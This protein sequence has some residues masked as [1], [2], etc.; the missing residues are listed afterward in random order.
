M[1]LLLGTLQTCLDSDAID[2]CDRNA[3]LWDNKNPPHL[4]FV[5]L[6]TNKKLIKQ[7]YFS[8]IF[9]SKLKYREINI[10]LEM[11]KWRTSL[12]YLKVQCSAAQPVWKALYCFLHSPCR[13]ASRSR[14]P[15]LCTFFVFVQVCTSRF[16]LTSDMHGQNSGHWWCVDKL[17]LNW[18]WK[19]FIYR[20]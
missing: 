14:H 5:I 20:T 7:I 13:G 11:T 6:L 8:W 19:K 1:L 4:T 2:E 9:S 3:W 12:H 18:N 10:I 15:I 17:K 16:G